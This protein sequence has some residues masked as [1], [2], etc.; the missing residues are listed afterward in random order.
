MCFC[1]QEYESDDDYYDGAQHKEGEGRQG[2]EAAIAGI[3]FDSD[4]D[5]GML[6]EE[7]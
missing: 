7:S 4:D 3:D 5:E 1:L 6:D 2:L